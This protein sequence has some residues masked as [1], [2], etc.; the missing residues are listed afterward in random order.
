LLAS[1]AGINTSENPMTDPI[2]PP[3]AENDARRERTRAERRAYYE[4]NSERINAER[5]RRYASDAEYRTKVLADN[6]KTA[7]EHRLRRTYGISL[8]DYDRMF[9][10]QGG[11]CAIC[12]KTSKHSLCVDHSHRTGMLRALLCISCNVGFGNFF[13]SPAFLRRAADYGEF[14]AA[15]EEEILRGDPA[16]LQEAARLRERMLSV[17][18][19]SLLPPKVGQERGA[20]RGSGASAKP[21]RRKIDARKATSPTIV[22]PGKP[23]GKKQAQPRPE[24]GQQSR[25]HDAER[26]P[27]RAAPAIRRERATPRRQAAPG[28]AQPGQQ[29]GKRRSQRNQGGSHAGRGRGRRVPVPSRVGGL[30]VRGR[31]KGLC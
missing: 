11:R 25:S 28:R 5:R 16:V 10:R 30:S 23:A 15:H 24:R 4:K 13:E 19:S 18:M 6:Q 20:G 14:F 1:A 29:H 2:Q 26:D 22:Q 12:W 8:Q 21:P 9:A 17:D 7:R 27:A 31:P 3:D